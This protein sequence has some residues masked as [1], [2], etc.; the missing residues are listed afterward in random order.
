[1]KRKRNLYFNLHKKLFN[2][3]YPSQFREIQNKQLF[4][5]FFG[6]KFRFFYKYVK[7][8]KVSPCVK[9]KNFYIFYVKNGIWQ[10][11]KLNKKIL[12]LSKIPKKTRYLR[13][14]QNFK[15]KQYRFFFFK[16]KF[17]LK[18]K[19]LHLKSSFLFIQKM[20]REL[21]KKRLKRILLKKRIWTTKYLAFTKQNNLI[22]Y[23]FLKKKWRVRFA[24]SRVKKFLKHFPIFNFKCKKKKFK[25]SLVT[26]VS[27]CSKKLKKKKYKFLR[28]KIIIFY[29]K[30]FYQKVRNFFK[31]FLSYLLLLRRPAFIMLRKQH[32]LTWNK[33]T[34]LNKNLWN[35]KKK[36]K[37]CYKNISLLQ[38]KQKVMYSFYFFFSLYYFFWCKKK[39]FQ[40]FF[41]KY[42]SFSLKEY[43]F[44]RKSKIS[45]NLFATLFLYY[46]R[47]IYLIKHKFW[48]FRLKKKLKRKNYFC[49]T[50]FL[51]GNLLKNFF[52]RLSLIFSHIFSL[53]FFIQDQAFVH[54]NFFFF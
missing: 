54:K 37:T 4:F 22:F 41:F 3:L 33:Y 7:N 24:F 39:K 8:G 6:W 23:K 2:E 34:N 40:H 26:F 30:F 46:K 20:K 19:K 1:M 53:K 29:L 51:T 17:I 47:Q 21:R 15:K 32:L 5:S 12:I 49:K 35:L 45:N 38:K 42:N 14:F 18:K 36:F 25:K 50:T 27:F 43:V 10:P 13:I 28:Q 11:R 16:Y 48:F 44:F 52:L 9:K 31:Y